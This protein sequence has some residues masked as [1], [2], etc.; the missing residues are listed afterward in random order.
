MSGI[1]YIPTH[2]YIFDRMIASND[3]SGTEQ[4][5]GQRPFDFVSVY[6]DMLTY[7]E[8]YN[9]GVSRAH[10]GRLAY[11]SRSKSE[12]LL[13]PSISYIVMSD[14]ENKMVI[15]GLF[16]DG[17]QQQGQVWINGKLV[18]IELWSKHLIIC[19]IDQE[20]NFSSGDV[21]V[22]FNGHLSNT[23]PLTSWTIPLTVTRDVAGV[24][25]KAK[26]T[27][28]LRGDVHRYRT[29]P[30]ATPILERPDSLG[31]GDE[32]NMFGWAFSKASSG[33]YTVSGARVTGCALGGCQITETQASQAQGG[34]LPFDANPV[35]LKYGA[36]YRWSRDLKK[37]R[38]G[39]VISVP[40]VEIDHSTKYRSCPGTNPKDQNHMAPEDVVITVPS[41][42]HE[43]IEFEFDENFNIVEGDKPKIQNFSWSLCNTPDSSTTRVEW[44]AVE[45]KGPPTAETSAR[46]FDTN[47]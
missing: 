14:Y 36:Y 47:P 22:G 45:A 38:V 34:D 6:K 28:R 2:R 17:P 40:N 33:T 23:V 41:A 42:E 10:G 5:P 46:A 20:G 26:L 7:P 11:N 30:N 13:T 27:L 8:V 35:E 32:Q 19:E 12:V 31:L 15:H 39:L 44:P 43:I 16:G 29:I 37:L 18:S 24:K 4:T 9:L 21:I 25:T 1:T 3:V